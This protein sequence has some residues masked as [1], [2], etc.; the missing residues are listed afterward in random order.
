MTLFAAWLRRNFHLSDSEGISLPPIM[1]MQVRVYDEQLVL[2]PAELSHRPATFDRVGHRRFTQFA[3][4][5]NLTWRFLQ[6]EEIFW[7]ASR[8]PHIN[9]AGGVD[10]FCDA[11]SSLLTSAAELF[12]MPVNQGRE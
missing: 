7:I 3:S 9:I 10:G 2:W 11:C 4:I 5:G 8:P 12:V 6:A 1:S